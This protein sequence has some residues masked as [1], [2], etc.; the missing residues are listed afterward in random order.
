MSI[1]IGN[2]NSIDEITEDDFR[3]AA[4]E[5]GMGAGFVIKLYNEMKKLFFSAVDQ[6]VGSMVKLGIS[7]AE[8]I[9]KRVK[10]MADRR[11]L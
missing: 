1:F 5:S 6:S 10:S 2:N 9:G 3:Q 4:S 8:F 7:E 11:V